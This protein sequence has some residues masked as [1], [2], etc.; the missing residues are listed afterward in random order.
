MVLF[1]LAMLPVKP[2][3][4]VMFLPS[5]FIAFDKSDKH[6]CHGRQFSFSRF[7]YRSFYKLRLLDRRQIILA[8]TF[9]FHL[10]HSHT[11]ELSF[12]LEQQHLPTSHSLV[13]V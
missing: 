2:I 8:E 7:D 10:V 9:P 11:S 5:P 4:S 13:I 1:P 6:V 12:P 3:I